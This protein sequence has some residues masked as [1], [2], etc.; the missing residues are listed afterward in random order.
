MTPLPASSMVFGDFAAR[1]IAGNNRPQ[2]PISS[3]GPYRTSPGPNPFRSTNYLAN[4]GPRKEAV[5]TRRDVPV[6]T[7]YLSNANPIP[8]PRLEQDP[9][10]ASRSYRPPTP[11]V[12]I[13]SRPKATRFQ[14]PPQ[15]PAKQQGSTHHSWEDRHEGPSGRTRTPTEDSDGYIHEEGSALGRVN[16]VEGPLIDGTFVREEHIDEVVL[17]IPTCLSTTTFARGGPDGFANIAGRYYVV[18]KRAEEYLGRSLPSGAHLSCAEAR[19]FF[20]GEF[21]ALDE[22][23]THVWR[24]TGPTN[25]KGYR[26]DIGRWREMSSRMLKVRE[27]TKEALVQSGEGLI[28]IPK[29]GKTGRVIDFWNLNDFEVLSV[30]FRA[31]AELFFNSVT[32][33]VL[34]QTKY[35][36]KED[37]N[38]SN[39]PANPPV[40]KGKQPERPSP[41]NKKPDSGTQSPEYGPYPPINELQ[42]NPRGQQDSQ[43]PGA[44]TNATHHSGERTATG[45]YH[46][47]PIPSASSGPLRINNP[48]LTP[49]TTRM[50]MTEGA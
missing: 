8:Q 28:D 41:V 32:R 39:V 25:E 50:G 42:S 7:E 40:N 10:N 34:T 37:E 5:E 19:E 20:Q 9:R 18:L 11:I 21:K 36:N 12:P 14:E 35:D 29:W 24:Y 31:E 33:S 49:A 44:R 16:N 15:D 38:S 48:Y 26:L 6:K 43:A 17:E 47:N 3:T 27:H 2:S 4:Y 45:G 22:L 13:I 1:A 23:L 46:P 30:G